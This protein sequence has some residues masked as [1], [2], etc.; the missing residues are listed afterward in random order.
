M[1]K[2]FKI[3]NIVKHLDQLTHPSID[4]IVVPVRDGVDSSKAQRSLTAAMTRSQAKGIKVKMKASWTV[5]GST[6]IP[7]IIVSKVVGDE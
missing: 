7:V 2:H 5:F 6:V 1:S 3:D 4:Y